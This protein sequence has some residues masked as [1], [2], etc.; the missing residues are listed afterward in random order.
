[1]SDTGDSVI[2][3]AIRRED[4]GVGPMPL[5]K[6][7]IAETPGLFPDVIIK[8]I[9][10]LASILIRASRAYVTTLI[11]LMGASMTG[12]GGDALVYHNFFH[13]LRDYAAVA[14]AAFVWSAIQNSGELLAKLDQ[15]FPMFRA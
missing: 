2:V 6:V 4:T 9:T 15:K 8:T 1:M 7:T 11:S 12:L 5:P 14:L 13:N 3:T 10:P